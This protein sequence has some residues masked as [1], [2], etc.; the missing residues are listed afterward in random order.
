M[1][2]RP[3]CARLSSVPWG[4]AAPG[5][6]PHRSSRS[7]RRPRRRRDGRGGRS[8]DRA[9]DA[10]GP[11]GRTVPRALGRGRPAPPASCALTGVVATRRGAGAHAVGTCV[12]RQAVRGVGVRASPA[13][14][15][16]ASARRRA[17]RCCS[18]TRSLRDVARAAE[19]PRRRGVHGSEWEP[20]WAGNLAVRKEGGGGG[21]RPHIV[22]G[23]NPRLASG[24]PP[25]LWRELPFGR[26]CRS[27]AGSSGLRV[28]GEPFEQLERPRAP[29][30]HRANG[31]L[32]A[33]QRP[34]PRAGRPARAR[35]GVELRPRA[36]PESGR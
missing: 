4:S 17:R 22:C 15:V 3:R 28:P 13:S 23:G 16:E 1:R 21:H 31:A 2:F 25:E 8:A 29:R 24:D 7:R 14:R 30:R 19:A 9:Q 12:L 11:P 32:T 5:R 36:L 34:G 27:H 26:T 10:S 20:I 18:C 35:A 6:A 33:R